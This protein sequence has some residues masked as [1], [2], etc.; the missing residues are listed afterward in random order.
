MNARNQDV[1]GMYTFVGGVI[2]DGLI[3]H[4]CVELF[5]EE[6]SVLMLGGSPDVATDLIVA[7]AEVVFVHGNPEILWATWERVEALLSPEALDGRFRIERREFD[8]DI[9]DLV[10]D[11]SI[12]VC[13]G[14]LHHTRDPRELLS[15]LVESSASLVVLDTT[16]EKMVELITAEVMSHGS[17]CDPHFVCRDAARQV[18]FN[19]EDDLLVLWKYLSSPPTFYQYHMTCRWCGKSACGHRGV[20]YW[21]GVWK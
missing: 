9:Q 3:F 21:F 5:H 8:E 10:E 13:A 4:T 6:P 20:E 17:A 18:G 19:V 15:Q 1:F 12:V 2:G 11:A 16:V 14:W 7:G